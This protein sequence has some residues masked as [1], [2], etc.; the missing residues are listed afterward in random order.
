MK[1]EGWYK[2]FVAALIFHAIIIGAFSIP[3]RKAV[4]KLDI[5]S[6][7]VNLVTDV[8]DGPAGSGPKSK[9]GQPAAVAKKEAPAS[10]AKKVAIPQPAKEKTA[11][12][13][14][15]EK[16]R[17]ISTVSEKAVKPKKTETA[18]PKDESASNEEV[19]NLDETIR[20]LK[21]RDHSTEVVAGSKETTSPK[22]QGSGGTGLGSGGT[23]SGGGT[24]EQKYLSDV[25]AKI[26]EVWSVPTI[27]SIRKDLQTAVTIKIRKDGRI[28]NWTI[29]ERS[30]SRMYD[31]SIVRALRTVDKLPPIP[32]ALSKDTLEL[33][34]TFH[35]PAARR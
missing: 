33:P 12:P 11:V 1:E 13:K 27:L 14:A 26:E 21:R 6:Y 29:D 23:G 31:E 17:S 30:N 7:S 4:R 28:M 2:M 25:L 35:P 16:E 24:A 9:A 3:L 10:S 15:V 32:D 22:A 5:P 18:S 20:Q 34:L 8:G 19:R